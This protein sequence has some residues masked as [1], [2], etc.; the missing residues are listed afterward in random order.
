MFVSQK[1]ISFVER[2][3]LFC[4][5]RFQL[6]EHIVPSEIIPYHVSMMFDVVAADGRIS[7][8]EKNSLEITKFKSP[9]LSCSRHFIAS[10]YLRHIVS[11]LR[12]AATAF[13]L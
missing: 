11:E 8:Y 5:C 3:E 1:F 10:R 4:E 7:V 13:S 2:I 12:S 9:D 6:T